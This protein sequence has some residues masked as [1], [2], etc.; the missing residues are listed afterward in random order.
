MDSGYEE[1]DDDENE[2]VDMDMEE[3]NYEPSD[4]SQH[5]LLSYLTTNP[6]LWIKCAPII[7]PKYF[8]KEFQETVTFVNE[9]LKKYKRMPSKMIIKSE[10]GVMFDT[11]DDS[12][13]EQI[14]NFICD[15]TEEFCRVEAMKEVMF[16]IADTVT[17]DKSKRVAM[18]FLRKFKDVN[19]ISL[20]RDLGDEFFKSV[21]HYLRDKDNNVLVPTGLPNVDLMLNGGVTLPS[22]NIASANSGQGKSV[23]L[24]NMAVNAAKRGENVVYY[25]MELTPKEISKRFAA[26]ISGYDINLLYRFSDDAITT[27]RA[28]REKDSYGSI[29][30]KSFPMTGTTMADII[31]HYND[32]VASEGKKYSMVLIDYFDLMESSSPVKVGDIAARDKNIIS[33]MHDFAY[34]NLL[35]IWTAA[36]VLKSFRDE[37]KASQSGVAGGGAKVDGSDNTIQF[38]SS[39]A[40]K[41]NNIFWLFF[42][43]ARTSNSTGRSVPIYWNPDTLVME[44]GPEELFQESNPVMAQI[45]ENKKKQSKVADDPIAKE[46]KY[47]EP[48]R[49]EEP[50][51]K[52]KAANEILNNLRKRVQQ[53]V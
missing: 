12:D 37:A 3:D 36:Q 20:N 30:I 35:V 40:D 29:R 44:D 1:Y 46:M 48:E 53:R 16:E 6:K 7:K 23:W 32:L 51:G 27:V 34:E 2:H 5:V 42:V 38:K 26:M 24:Q 41:V 18:H 13:D 33:E 19:D 39:D 8:D 15:K 25:T 21:E 22:V 10:T 52:A 31:S 43:K 47:E 17:K 45:K 50:V 28:K 4:L 9:F 49:K 14:Y 11:P